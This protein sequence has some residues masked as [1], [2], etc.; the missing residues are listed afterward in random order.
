MASMDSAFSQPRH[1]SKAAATNFGIV[2]QKYSLHLF[3]H[4]Q[5]TDEF[6]RHD[7]VLLESWD[8]P[9]LKIAG[10]CSNAPPGTCRYCVHF[11]PSSSM[12]LSMTVKTF[13]WSRSKSTC[14]ATVLL[15]AED[16]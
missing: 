3:R 5:D 10:C 16:T 14:V 7:E 11:E 6:V 12:I 4:S 9:R 13:P 15:R 1:S 2:F 8:L